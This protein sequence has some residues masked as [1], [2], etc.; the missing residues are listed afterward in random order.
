MAT[1]STKST[2]S[3]GTR[4]GDTNAP[5]RIHLRLPEYATVQ[6]LMKHDF[7]KRTAYR[8]INEPSRIDLETLSKLCEVLSCEPSDILVW[9]QQ[10]TGA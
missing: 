3:L 8:L 10:A 7:V 9:R 5:N 4:N 1:S 2:V 6:W